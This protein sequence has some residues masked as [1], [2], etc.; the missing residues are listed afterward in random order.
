MPF[1]T[2]PIHAKDRIAHNLDNSRP[3]PGLQ[4][5]GW[6][7][8]T[9]KTYSGPDTASIWRIEPHSCPRIEQNSAAHLPLE[10]ALDMLAHLIQRDLGGNRIEPIRSPVFS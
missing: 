4:N 7:R 1:C 9:S 8:G 2:R 5:T 6:Q 10:Q 3:D